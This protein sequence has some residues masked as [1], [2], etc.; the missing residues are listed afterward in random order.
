MKCLPPTS[1]YREAGKEDIVQTFDPSK[2][3]GANV[4]RFLNYINLCLGNRFR[5]LHSKRMKDALSNPRNVSLD[6]HAGWDDPGSIDD[7]YC[8]EHSEHLR[9]ASEHLEKQG[10]DRRRITEFTDFVSREDSGVVPAIGAI[11]TT[12]TQADAA[13]F[14]RTTDATFARMRTRLRHLGKCFE[15]GEPVPR[16]R[17]PYKKRRKGVAIRSLAAAA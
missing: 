8:H 3:Q 7:V 17:R 6:T 10:Q 5:S 1:K 11:L 9:R 12:D 4:R 15:D 2:H 16:Q 14:L 13:G